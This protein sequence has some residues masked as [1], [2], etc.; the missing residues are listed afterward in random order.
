M[1]KHENGMKY[2]GQFKFFLFSY[3]NFFKILFYEPTQ[4]QE[5]KIL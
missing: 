3:G 5:R 4:L 1:G 2:Y